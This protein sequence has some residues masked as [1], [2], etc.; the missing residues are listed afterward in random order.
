MR[1]FLLPEGTD[2]SRNIK[3]TGQDYHYLFH[4]LRLK[5]GDE[6][7]G[8][9]GKG[10][11]WRLE[12]LQIHKD[13]LLLRADHP[14]TI[15]G[16]AYRISLLQCLPRGRKMDGIIRQATEAGVC[17]I[18]PI[19]SANSVF[20]IEAA[21]EGRKK[22]KRWQRIAREAMQQSG[23]AR[24]P[25]IE[26]PAL[27]PEITARMEKEELKVFFHQSPIAAFTLHNLLARGPGTI[28]LCVGPE[29]GFTADEVELLKEREFYPVYMG[30][31]VLRT[32]TAGIFAVAAVQII[33]QESEAWK[34]T[35]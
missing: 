25:V 18:I 3:I 29:G 21:E 33:L 26:Q 14:Q 27:L 9:D 35:G 15:A 31:T 19:I 17:R 8:T 32:E 4:I 1:L 7:R 16:G 6:L 28:S 13:S 12:V 24:L 30:D 11:A 2:S 34:V 20:R 10:T 23:A 22:V 5:K